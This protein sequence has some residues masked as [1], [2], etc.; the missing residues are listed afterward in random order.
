MGEVVAARLRCGRAP[1]L[2]ASY[3]PL[4]TRPVVY[5]NA[6]LPPLLAARCVAEGLPAMVMPAPLDT[7][8]STVFLAP[9][10]RPAPL[11]ARALT[12]AQWSDLALTVAPE[13]DSALAL[14]HSPD[15]S[16]L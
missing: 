5:S 3:S 7:S 9:M 8:A 2:R 1:R 6:M 13:L 4:T 14:S 15:V 11:E 10:L 12:S 16:R